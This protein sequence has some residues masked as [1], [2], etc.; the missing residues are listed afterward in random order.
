MVEASTGE[1]QH[2]VDRRL[3]Y[4]PG[5]ELCADPRTRLAADLHGPEAY[6]HG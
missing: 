5:L 1:R 2:N 6:E 4:L 3:I